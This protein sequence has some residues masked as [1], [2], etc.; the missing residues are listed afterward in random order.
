MSR[1]QV[2][3][4]LYHRA[5]CW[6][7]EGKSASLL[8]CDPATAS[9]NFCRGRCAMRKSNLDIWKILEQPV[10]KRRV[11]PARFAKPLWFKSFIMTMDQKISVRRSGITIVAELAKWIEFKSLQSRRQKEMP[12]AKMLRSLFLLGGLYCR[13]SLGCGVWCDR[14]RRQEAHLRRLRKICASSA[15]HDELAA[16]ECKLLNTKR[17]KGVKFGHGCYQSNQ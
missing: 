6:A 12:W 15:I 17:K 11:D 13:R 4:K 10:C 14:Q 7:I 16:Q 9:R 2:I 3:G 1:C 8:L 5:W